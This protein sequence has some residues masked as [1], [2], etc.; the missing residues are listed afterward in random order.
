MEYFLPYL[1]INIQLAKLWDKITDQNEAFEKPL[2]ALFSHSN[3]RT[4]LHFEYK[5]YQKH[6]G[7]IIEVPVKTLNLVNS[8]T[9]EYEELPDSIS[10]V[11]SESTGQ[12]LTHDLLESLAKV[13]A[14][15]F[16]PDN[17]VAIEKILQDTLH[18]MEALTKEIH[19]YEEQL[20][21]I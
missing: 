19:S 12:S 14:P 11:K 8:V 6:N 9:G 20:I 2:F 17:I 16:P 21:N 3:K 7:N 1:L 4:A 13:N 18:H 5:L 15:S 10:L